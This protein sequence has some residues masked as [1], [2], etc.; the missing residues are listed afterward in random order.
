MRAF[1]QAPRKENAQATITTGM[2]VV[3]KE[4]STVVRD[5]QLYYG[6]V[7]PCTLRASRTCQA[8]IGR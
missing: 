1:R 6:G 7:G 5:V 4:G 2:R 3:F 8:L